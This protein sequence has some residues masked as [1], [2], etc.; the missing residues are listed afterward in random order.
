MTFFFVAGIATY[1][2]FLFVL[3]VKELTEHGTELDAIAA[4]S[5]GVSSLIAVFVAGV[6]L[7][8]AYK[9]HRVSIA[10][11]KEHTFYMRSEFHKDEA[12]RIHLCNAGPGVAIVDKFSLKIFGET[13]HYTQTTDE[14]HVEFYLEEIQDRFDVDISPN[15]PLPGTV[16]APGHEL[17]ILVI[18]SKNIDGRLNALVETT[19]FKALTKDIHGNINTT[20]SRFS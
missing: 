4:T 6:S 11:D 10:K 12:L 9:A 7:Y 1:L 15:I 13:T 18:T 8:I 17:D 3:V 20:E 16:I 2:S 14:S 5:S 19:G